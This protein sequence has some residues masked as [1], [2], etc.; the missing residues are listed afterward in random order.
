MIKLSTD[1]SWSSYGIPVFVDETPTRYGYPAG[2]KKLRKEKKWS[3]RDLAA[4]CG[5]S[6]RTVEDWEQGRT[7]PRIESLLRLMFI[8]NT[9]ENKKEVSGNA[10]NKP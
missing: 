6:H 2:F 8:L 3:V 4:K 10:R 7:H 5:V 1:C 9:P